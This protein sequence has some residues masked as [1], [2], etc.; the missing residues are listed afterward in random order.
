M[1]FLANNEIVFNSDTRDSSFANVIVQGSSTSLRVQN[2]PNAFGTASGYTSGGFPPDLNT[3]DKFPFATD[4]NATDVG[5]LSQSRIGPAGQSSKV[6]GYS[7]GGDNNLGTF[8][9]T[10]DKFPFATDANATDV[11][12]LTE[13]RS[14]SAGQSSDTHGYT[15]GGTYDAPPSPNPSHINTIDKFSFAFDENANDVGDLTQ[16]R[17]FT[18]G[19]SSR[20]HGYTSGGRLNPPTSVFP[21][22]IDKFPF[23]TDTS[24]SD[25]GDLTQ[26]RGR[27]AGQSSEVSGYTSGGGQPG[28]VNIIDKFPFA[29]DASATD[30]GDLTTVKENATGQSS[31]VSGYTSGGSPPGPNTIQKFP[32][33][34]DTNASDVGDLTVARN[35][36]AGQQV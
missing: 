10:I 23:S 17:E 4:T 7:S 24:A 20:T 35:S 1:T 13:N 16:A 5:D 21:N 30:V 33:A 32:F 27:S 6:S 12:N 9:D 11:G 34:T 26:G 19:Q 36:A 31:N 29:A 18:T 2:F 25:V 15:S 22:V 8:Y 3:I 14:A 28:D